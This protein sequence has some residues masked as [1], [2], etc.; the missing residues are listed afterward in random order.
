MSTKTE[1][2]KAIQAKQAMRLLKFLSDHGSCP[3]MTVPGMATRD[4]SED[5]T[6]LRA[7]GGASLMCDGSTLRLLIAADLI[8]SAPSG[9]RLTAVGKARLKRVSAGLDRTK[10]DIGTFRMQHLEVAER[11]INL[12]GR[13][14]TVMADE[15]ESPLARLHRMKAPAG[16]NWLDDAAFA[17]GERLRA[18]FHPRPHDAAHHI[19]VEF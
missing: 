2:K 17:A 12:D 6:L 19:L 13:M 10:A 3:G 4:G 8:A 7:T 18:R 14:E 5:Q 16:G 15:A 1:P 9:Y 11:N